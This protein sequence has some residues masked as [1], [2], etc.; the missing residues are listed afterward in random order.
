MAQKE[1]PHLSTKEMELQVHLHDEL[2]EEV[3]Q[4][5]K[6]MDVLAVALYKLIDTLTTTPPVAAPKAQPASVP[7]VHP[8]LK[9]GTQKPMSDKE[10][11]EIVKK[12]AEKENKS[13]RKE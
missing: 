8:D 12:V 7:V 10:A 2:L 3:K 11:V 1:R 4:L 13:G 9:V 5:R 6:E